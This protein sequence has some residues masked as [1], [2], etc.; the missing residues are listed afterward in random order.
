MKKLFAA[1][2]TLPASQY[3]IVTAP[4]RQRFAALRIAGVFA[5]VAAVGVMVAIGAAVASWLVPVAMV[6]G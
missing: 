6:Y 5:K 4:K 1:T 2:I 3:T